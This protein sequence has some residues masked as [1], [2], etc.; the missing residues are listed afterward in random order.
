[1]QYRG[2]RFMKA[3]PVIR[4]RRRGLG[5]AGFVLAA[6]ALVA[7][8]FAG[9]GLLGGPLFG[10]FVL[11]LAGL[12]V[13]AFSLRLRDMG[14]SIWLQVVP[15]GI[16]AGVLAWFFFRAWEGQDQA[17]LVLAPSL[18]VIGAIW[19]V[20]FSWLVVTPTAPERR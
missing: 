17:N 20:F 1:M 2:G 19:L 5:R 16:T 8:W 13:C 3:V 4:K 14:W 15:M 11:V 18:Q 10:P 7:S 9:L 12:W 6:L